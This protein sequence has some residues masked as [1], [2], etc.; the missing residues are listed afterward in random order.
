M[1]ALISPFQSLGFCI[2]ALQIKGV[3]QP[4]S[5]QVRDVM[6]LMCHDIRLCVPHPASARGPT[7]MEK[8]VIESVSSCPLRTPQHGQAPLLNEA[9]N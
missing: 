6:S 9:H 4:L 3:E 5:L 2:L 7:S 1:S 8:A